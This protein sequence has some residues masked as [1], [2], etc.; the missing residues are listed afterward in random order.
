MIEILPVTSLSRVVKESIFCMF[1]LVQ[2]ESTKFSITKIWSLYG[3]PN[4]YSVL[5]QSPLAG[6]GGL[7][8]R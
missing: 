6:E 4:V 8:A 2:D 5:T 3:V 7:E 1:S